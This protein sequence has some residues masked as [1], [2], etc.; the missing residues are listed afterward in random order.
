MKQWC[1]AGQHYNCK[2]N[3]IILIIIVSVYLHMQK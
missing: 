2:S 3:I 1:K